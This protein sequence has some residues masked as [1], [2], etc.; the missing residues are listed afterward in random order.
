[1]ILRTLRI[2]RLL[3]LPGDL[4]AALAV[5]PTIAEH[6]AS[7]YEMTRTL[8]RISDDTDALPPLR[9]DMGRVAEA[10]SIL[11]EVDAKLKAISEAM[12]ILVEVQRHLDQLPE[13][14]AGLDAGM[15][16]LSVLI[17]QMLPPMEALGGNVET[18]R[19]E[20]GPVSRLA[21]RVPGQRNH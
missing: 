20:L 15:A 6:T 3:R 1:M 10:T 5:V 7:L 12:P 17:E 9:G 11:P 18:L 21:S 8:K 13:T 19:E 4:A 2:D 16:R 14:M